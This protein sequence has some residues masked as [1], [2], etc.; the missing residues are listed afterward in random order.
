M[1]TATTTNGKLRKS[2]SEQID[3]LDAIL[4][5]LSAALNESAAAA[6]QEAVGLAVREAVQAVLTE[7]L[8]NPAVLALLNGGSPQQVGL[9]VGDRVR[10]ALCFV[11]AKARSA[12]SGCKVLC[13]RVG[14]ALTGILSKLAVVRHFKLQVLTALAVGCLAGTAVYFAGPWLAVAAGGVGGFAVTAAVQGW[15]W[16]RRVLGTAAVWRG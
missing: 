3:R 15:L 12:V 8:A 6:V 11:A 10:V 2:L 9:T 5:G 1:E 16:L 14:R 13:G 4:D 7:L